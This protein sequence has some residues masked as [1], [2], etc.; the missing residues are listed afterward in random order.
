MLGAC[1]FMHVECL[2]V[3]VGCLYVHVECLC[4]HVGACMCMLSACMC[5]LC[6]SV[7]NVEWWSLL[8][9]LCGGEGPLLWMGPRHGPVC[10]PAQ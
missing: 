9:G 3:H 1:V 7:H 5:M 4:V 8:Q 6:A 2:C 10:I